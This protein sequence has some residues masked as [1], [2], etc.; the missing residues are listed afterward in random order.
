MAIS[1]SLLFLDCVKTCFESKISMFN[2]AVRTFAVRLSILK[3]H[4]DVPNGERCENPSFLA[5][6]IPPTFRFSMCFTFFQHKVGE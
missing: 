5:V 1:S 4:H 3:V 2:G 6:L